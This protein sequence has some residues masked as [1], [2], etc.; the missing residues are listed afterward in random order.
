MKITLFGCGAMGSIYAALLATAGNEVAVVDTNEDHIAAINANGLR[1]SGASGDRIANI[2]A[3]TKA[4]RTTAELII[5]AVKGTQVGSVLEQALA[6]TNKD[7]L[8]LTIQ[9]GLG[10]SDIIAEKFDPD[11][12]IVGIAQGFGASLQEPGHAHHK[13]MKAIRMGAYGNLNSRTVAKVAQL[14]VE[15]GFDAE[16]VTDIK[17]M[18]WDKLICNC[19]YSA[20]AALT[21]MNVGQI[22]TDPN[23]STISRNAATEAWEIANALNIILDIPDPVKHVQEFASRMPE[24]KPSVLLDVEAGRASEVDMINGAIP[25]EASKI[26]LTAPI[27]DTLN[28]L[29]LSLEQSKFRKH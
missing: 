23:I 19:A 5:I 29:V 10:S 18:Q 8:I 22:M 25:R 15:A 3:H 16:P 11:R 14:Y 20:L 6:I 12:L 9:N 13:D 24:A 2:Q 26:S 28:Q 21:N 27:N 7:S 4:T 17:A 1:I